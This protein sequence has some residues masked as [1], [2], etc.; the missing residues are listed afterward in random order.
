[1]ALVECPE[2]NRV[3]SDTVSNCPHCGYP[4]PGRTKV[5]ERISNCS[6]C[7]RTVSA[8]VSG[9]PYC[10]FLSPGKANRRSHTSNDGAVSGSPSNTAV[11][12]KELVPQLQQLASLHGSGALSDAEYQSAKGRI[13]RVNIPPS[14]SDGAPLPAIGGRAGQARRSGSRLT[15]LEIWFSYSGRLGVG[16]YWG[17]FL[18]AL[19]GYAVLSFALFFATADQ[20][21]MQTGIP[22]VLLLLSIWTGTALASKRLHDQGRSAWFL[23]V[24]LVPIFNLVML[25]LS[26]TSRPNRY[27]PAPG[28]RN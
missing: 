17:R 9:C 24:L 10:G 21:G 7:G 8:N 14:A 20:A 3:V 5:A 2:C 16:Q 25:S 6:H 26:G 11:S 13:L 15:E 4:D 12:D 27:G 1:M 18:L 19:V 23:L 22:E 28:Y